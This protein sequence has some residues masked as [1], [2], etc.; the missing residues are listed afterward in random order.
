MLEDGE[1]QTALSSASHHKINQ[2]GA[3]E[4]PRR[5]SS[6]RG[7]IVRERRERDRA[8]EEEERER[9]TA[10][11]SPRDGFQIDLTD[12]RFSALYDHE[13]HLGKGPGCVVS[14]PVMF[15][16]SRIDNIILNPQ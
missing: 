2:G 7:Y 8:T 3:R 4:T 6:Y 10:S 15:I 12:P 16:P 11:P 1:L 5:R 13:S 14:T 9:N